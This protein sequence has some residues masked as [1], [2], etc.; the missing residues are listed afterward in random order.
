MKFKDQTMRWPLMV[1]AGF[2]MFHL[3]CLPLRG[4]NWTTLKTSGEIDPREEAAFMACKGKFYLMGGYGLMP[5]NKFD[6]ETE[7]WTRG[8]VPPVEMHHFQAVRLGEEI[9]VLG[10]LTGSGANEKALDHIYIYDTTRDQWRMGDPIPKDRVRGSAGV[11]AYRGMIYMIGGTRDRTR[12]AG[13]DFMDRYDPGT[14]KWKK[15][16]DA[17]RARDY[18]HAGIVNGKIYA[19]GGRNTSLYSMNGKNENIAEVDV[20]DIEKGR[21]ATLP[22]SLNLPTPRAG[23]A[24]AE[25]IDHIL[26]IGGESASSPTACNLVEALD[27]ERGKWETWN[28]L[29]EGRRGTQAFMCIGCVFVASGSSTR[30]TGS[31]LA[32][33]ER[34]DF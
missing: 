24:T 5:V 29:K 21:W 22:P 9:Y 11:V 7:V 2:L 15:L 30:E 8:A 16:A 23:C 3:I 26:V 14:G 4:Q 18:F 28:S 19:A 27:V 33:I 6:P 20:Y 1:P 34:L 25:I 10:A 31:Q 32:S 13:T 12:G 17:P